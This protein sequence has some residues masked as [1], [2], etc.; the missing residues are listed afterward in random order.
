MTFKEFAY[1]AN[2]IKT[3][4]TKENV[5]R[6]NEAM[7]IWYDLLK[8][9]DFHTTLAGLQKWCAS[10][11]WSPTIADI[12]KMCTEFTSLPIP[13]FGE[14][15]GEVAQA[16][17]KYG[18]MRETEALAS[19]SP[20]TAKVVRY[21]GWQAICESENPETLRAQFRQMYEIVEKREKQDAQL[22]QALKDTIENIQLES[23]QKAQLS[24]AREMALPP[25]KET[26]AKEDLKPVDT[27]DLLTR[28]EKAKRAS[29]VL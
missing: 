8:D 6:T 23:R 9:L 2:V 19:M 16:I 7:E 17:R 28:L 14:A 1:L 22:P 10:E 29:G 13:N 21:I 3:T 27:N 4:Y 26:S 20:Q 25:K 11:Q 15:W 12:R 18:Y 5:L 24:A